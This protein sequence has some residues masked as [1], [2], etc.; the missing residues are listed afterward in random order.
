MHCAD[1]VSHRYVQSRARGSLRLARPL[2]LAL[3]L[4]SLMILPLSTAARAGDLISYE[5]Y[6]ALIAR[7]RQDV[8]AA[9][10]RS[11]QECAATLDRIASELAAVTA[12]EMPDGTIMPFE[13]C[14]GLE[15]ALRALRT[16]HEQVPGDALLA[17]NL[18]WLLAT[19]ARDDLRDPRGALRVIGRVCP[20]AGGGA[21]SCPVPF[22]D[23]AAAAHAALD[24]FDR[25][26][27]IAE[28]AAALARSGRDPDQA[29]AL[30]DRLRLYRSGKPYLE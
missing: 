4:T 6:R 17:H 1:A 11:P 7:A 21:C 16:A 22:L 27:D 10:L 20:G 12:V 14:C 26:I 2:I 5:E 18:A 25:A 24:E 3:A 9:G 8:H 30:E 28:R 19:T 13:L 23:A 15:E 29:R